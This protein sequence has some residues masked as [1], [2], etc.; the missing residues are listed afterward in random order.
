[1]NI[2][3][4]PP[5]MESLGDVLENTDSITPVGH[6]PWSE[7]ETKI[8]G[9]KGTYRRYKNDRR[10]LKDLIK[11]TALDFIL[12][13]LRFL[14]WGH[15]AERFWY[16]I[17]DTHSFYSTVDALSFCYY[18]DKYVVPLRDAL[19]GKRHNWHEYMTV[20]STKGPY[21]K[22]RGF[23]RFPLW[24]LTKLVWPRF[25]EIHEMYS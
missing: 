14:P 7:I 18:G 3:V 22:E 1:M 6:T 8:W 15:V 24:L 12:Y 5:I 4:A 19:A 10:H 21:I 25:K 23:Y 9:A 13:P 11:D 2:V 16:E 20:P 17:I